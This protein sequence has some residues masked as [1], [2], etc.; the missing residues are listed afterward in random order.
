MSLSTAVWA[1]L[2]DY[3]VEFIAV[4]DDIRIL[5][6]EFAV[7]AQQILALRVSQ[8]PTAHI[9]LLER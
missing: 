9:G 1:A 3:A 8:H 2:G 4:A 7:V 6:S 5:P